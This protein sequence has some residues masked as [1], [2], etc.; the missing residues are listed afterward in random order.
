VV[1]TRDRYGLHAYLTAVENA[2]LRSKLEEE[3]QA[4]TRISGHRKMHL[5]KVL[6]SGTL[7]AEELHDVDSVPTKTASL[8]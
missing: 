6:D 4:S 2:N 5:G 7:P 8:P 1:A 3:L